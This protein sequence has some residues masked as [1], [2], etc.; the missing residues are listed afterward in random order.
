MIET[1]YGAYPPSGY[2][3]TLA[4]PDC[5]A[6]HPSLDFAEGTGAHPWQRETALAAERRWL[7]PERELTCYPPPQRPEPALDALTDA[8]SDH[9][10][11]ANADTWEAGYDERGDE[12]RKYYSDLCW[13]ITTSVRFQAAR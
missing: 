12:N 6:A 1:V 9:N 3:W 8:D 10:W 2:W 7:S 4:C 5:G 13:P 11:S